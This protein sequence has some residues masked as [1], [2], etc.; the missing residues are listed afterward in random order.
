M[1]LVRDKIQLKW[2]EISSENQQLKKLIVVASTK[3]E[4][5]VSVNIPFQE[6]LH[7]VNLFNTFSRLSKSSS[8]L[9]GFAIT[10]ND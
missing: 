8:F 6:I 4:Y 7:G 3:T 5:T 10:K 2:E 1:C 9:V